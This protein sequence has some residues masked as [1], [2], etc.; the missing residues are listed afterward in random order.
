[1]A[2]ESEEPKQKALKLLAAAAKWMWVA[3][4]MIHCHIFWALAV[5]IDRVFL[6]DPV[7]ELQDAMLDCLMWVPGPLMTPGIVIWIVNDVAGSFDEIQSYQISYIIWGVSVGLIYTFYAFWAHFHPSKTPSFVERTVER[8]RSLSAHTST[9]SGGVTK[10][11]ES[12]LSPPSDEST[13]NTESAQSNANG[14]ST[15][16]APIDFEEEFCK[17]LLLPFGL[18]SE[19]TGDSFNF[20]VPLVS[21]APAIV[22]GYIAN[23]ILE[24]TYSLEC[25]VDFNSFA[26]ICEGEGVEKVCCITVSNH[27]NWFDFLPDLAASILAGWGIVKLIATF[28]SSYDEEVVLIEEEPPTILR[29]KTI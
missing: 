3:A 2:S 27:Q 6:A 1:M 24:K 21:L 4:W 29:S 14:T 22:G 26:D 25:D 28:I 19:D 10:T 23:F 18:R 7:P 13:K 15:E 8:V 12:T 17:I 20:T 11:T 5:C 16:S 9:P